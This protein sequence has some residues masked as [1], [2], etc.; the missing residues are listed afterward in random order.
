MAGKG[1]GGNFDLSRKRKLIFSSTEKSGEK[2]CVRTKMACQFKKNE[3]TKP[4]I[5][6]VYPKD[7]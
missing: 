7:T 3:Y 1:G 6:D 2:N 4:L 5:Q